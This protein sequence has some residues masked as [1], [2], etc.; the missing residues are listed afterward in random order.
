MRKKKPKKINFMK[1]YN[2]GDIYEYAPKK[3]KYFSG[4]KLN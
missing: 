1:L 3:W 2:K 4:A